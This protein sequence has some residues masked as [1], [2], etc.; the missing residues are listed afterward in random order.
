[1]YVDVLL[2]SVSHWE[3]TW[4][5][6]TYLSVTLN[7]VYVDVLLYSVSHWG[8]WDGQLWLASLWLSE[9]C[10]C[11]CTA[12]QCVSLWGLTW[13]ALTYLSVT[14]WTVCMWMYCFTVCLTVRTDMDSSNL[15]LCDTLNCVYVD[16]LLYSVSHC[17]DWHG[18]L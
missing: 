5:A 6:L 4:T 12:L 15:P 2:Y 7:C 1:M 13:T 17:E 9:L 3:L 16:V 18:Q 14:L 8:L 11:G 10:V